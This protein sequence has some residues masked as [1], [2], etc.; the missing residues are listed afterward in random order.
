[1]EELLMYLLF[2]PTSSRQ[3]EID[4][5]NRWRYSRQQ[6]KERRRSKNRHRNEYDEDE[7][8][9]IF[10]ANKQRKLKIMSWNLCW[11]CVTENENDKTARKLANKCKRMGNYRCLANII[12]VLTEKQYDIIALQEA[13]NWKNIN[14]KLVDYDHVH[15]ISGNEDML[16]FYNPDRLKYL[17]HIEGEVEYGRPFQFILFKDRNTGHYL[18]FI[19]LHNGQG[20]RKRQLQQILMDTFEDEFIHTTKIRFASIIAGDFNDRDY[21]YWQGIRLNN[22]IILSCATKPPKTCCTG[23]IS[24]RTLYNNS[25]NLIGDYILIDREKMRFVEKNRVVPH[26]KWDGDVFP[27][28]DH[29]PVECAVVYRDLSK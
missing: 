4:Y 8:R 28:S 14:K 7:P 29:L 23:Y 10:D 16:T 3:Q 11:G 5:Q 21:N 24:I 20:V 25:D 1:M 26:F 2:P 9:R 18:L 19:N 22:E 6:E 27:T 13:S 12:K 17:K 15:S